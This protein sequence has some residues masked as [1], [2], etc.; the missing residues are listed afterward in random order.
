MRCLI[1]KKSPKLLILHYFNICA[2]IKV[3]S[4]PSAQNAILRPRKFMYFRHQVRKMR[5][6]APENLFLISKNFKFTRF[7]FLTSYTNFFVK[8]IL[9]IAFFILQTRTYPIVYEITSNRRR[10]AIS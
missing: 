9:K 8:I 6:Y 10:R 7:S 1:Q 5:I 2:G 3:F 4:A